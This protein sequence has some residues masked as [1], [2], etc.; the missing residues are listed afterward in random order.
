[1]VVPVALDILGRPYAQAPFRYQGK[2]HDAL[3]KKQ[4]T[5]LSGRFE[6]EAALRRLLEGTGFSAQR[7]GSE[8]FVV[9]AVTASTG[10]IKGRLLT[11]DGSPP[12]RR[13]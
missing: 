9:T 7:N 13:P 11:P 2:C 6:P 12:R 3:R 5:A 10:S 8:R 1:M 4:S